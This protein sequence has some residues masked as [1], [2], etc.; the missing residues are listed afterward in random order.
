MIPEFDIIP[1]EYDIYQNIWCLLIYILGISTY[2]LNIPYC[3]II[4]YNY[5]VFSNIII[6]LLLL[7]SLT[8]FN[9][10]DYYSYWTG[11]KSTYFKYKLDL[12]PPYI[13]IGLLCKQNYLLFRL[14]I[15]GSALLGFI[16]SS[17]SLKIKCNFSTYYLFA[18][19]IIIFSYARATL[20]MSMIF[21]GYIFFY[22]YKNK[23][24]ILSSLGLFVFF[25]GFYFHRSIIILMILT[26]IMPF[27]KFS[28]KNILFFVLILPLF[29]ILI[30]YLFNYFKLDSHFLE[31]ETLRKMNAYSEKESDNKNIY[32]L[33]QDF[34]NYLRF[35]AP[36]FFIIKSLYFNNQ[37]LRISKIINNL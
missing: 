26:V 33:L 34:L 13:T 25:I 32:G 4:N 37:Y 3:K 7:Y 28:K 29:F 12:E 36:I 11:L 19:Y 35:Y 18:C 21:F 1:K 10:H 17:K 16:L 14:I 30:R 27:I 22:N 24:L 31:E 6:W 20:A 9:G 2:K 23:N 5:K 15:W 8:S